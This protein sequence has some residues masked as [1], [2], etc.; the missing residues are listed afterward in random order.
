[1]N[2]FEARTAFFIVGLLYLLL[3]IFTWLTLL[4]QRTNA[5]L[6]SNNVQPSSR[7]EPVGA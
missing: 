5:I 1:M 2:L 4:Q 3:P 7:G 6:I